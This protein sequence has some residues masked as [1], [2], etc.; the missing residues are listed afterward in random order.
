[1]K[2][3]GN[4]LFLIL[5]AVAL[6]AALSYAVTQSGRGG[7]SIDR[8]QASLRAAQVVQYM[9]LVKNSVDKLGLVGGCDTSQL[10]FANDSDGDGNFYDT[11]D[12]YHNSTA[13]NDFSCHV[14]QTNG[15]GV[16]AAVPDSSILD[17]THSAEGDF[18][19]YVFTRRLAVNGVGVQNSSDL[20][21]VINYVTDAFCLEVNNQ[22]GITNP[23]GAPPA[24]VG[25]FNSTNQF[26]GSFEDGVSTANPPGM[27]GE[28]LGCF[29]DSG[30]TRNTVYS[31]LV[32]R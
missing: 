5:I 14:F 26:E 32:A 3:S 27:E 9:G 2:Q 28:L 7:G 16:T 29:Q 19:E 8:E 18:G 22:L 23:S 30:M 25:A 13:P 4:A 31:V 12:D 10:S 21:I 11:D 6:F 15:G 1:M 17:S 24:D 20:S